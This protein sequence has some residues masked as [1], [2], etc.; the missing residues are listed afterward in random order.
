M[1]SKSYNYLGPRSRRNASVPTTIKPTASVATLK[2][3]WHA[4]ASPPPQRIN[5]ER[6]DQVTLQ[7][8]NDLS[9]P[10]VDKKTAGLLIS[11]RGK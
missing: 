9:N 8:G 2:T 6:Q 10:T 4:E 5:F 1:N 7:T 11:S 3:T